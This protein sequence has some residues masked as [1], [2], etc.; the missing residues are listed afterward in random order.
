MVAPNLSRALD[1]TNSAVR[2]EIVELLGHYGLSAVPGLSRAAG[3]PDEMVRREATAKLR[4]LD[5]EVRDGGITRGSRKAK[6]IAV[7]FTGHEFAEGGEAIL[8]AL[9]GR[10]GK[11]AVFLTGEFLRTLNFKPLVTRIVQE[12][13]FLGPHSDKHLLYCPW[14]GTKRTLV[15]RRQF[16]SD[17]SRN[18]QDALLVCTNGTE[19]RFFLPPYEHY[20]QEIAEWSAAMG[21]TVIN[22]TPGTRSNADYTGEADTNFVSSQAIFES[23]V[24]KEREDPHGLN[25]FILL[26]HLGSGPGRKDKFHYRFGELLDYLAGKGY[27]FVRV[28]ELLEPKEAE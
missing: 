27:E 12:G 14:D 11:A 25:G 20:N 6:K 13:H 18:I 5:V 21:L 2:V 9:A 7:V 4:Q 19:I 23:I 15:T 22:F 24:K 1:H 28:D 10:E 8:D 3:D 16:L 17:L 26:F